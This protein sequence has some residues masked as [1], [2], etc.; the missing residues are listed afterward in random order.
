MQEKERFG[1]I[2]AERYIVGVAHANGP[3]DSVGGL[4]PLFGGKA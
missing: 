2:N 4:C 3:I 1:W